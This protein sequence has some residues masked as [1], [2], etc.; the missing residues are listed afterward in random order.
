M[1][2]TAGNRALDFVSEQAVLIVKD[3]R[4]GQRLVPGT[5]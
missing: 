4:G 1:A 5:N 3:I 2:S